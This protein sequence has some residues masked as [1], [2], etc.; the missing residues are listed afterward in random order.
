M[1]ET[2]ALPIAADAAV[3]ARTAER[4]NAIVTHNGPIVLPT[5]PQPAFDHAEPAPANQADFTCLA[6]VANLPAI[7]LPAGTAANGMPIGIQLIGPRGA[8]AGLFAL[9]RQLD[10]HLAAYRQPNYFHQG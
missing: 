3:L 5:V 4:L 8:E 1:P 10:A 7:T 9:A 2:R 6:N